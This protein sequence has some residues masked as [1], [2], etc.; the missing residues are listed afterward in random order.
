M[1]YLKLLGMALKMGKNSKEITVNGY[2]FE[3]LFKKFDIGHIDLLKT[4][5]K[6]CECFLNEQVFTNV[7][8][9]K[10]EFET[11]FN[12]LKL[13]DFLKMLKNAGF[14]CIVYRFNPYN[15]TFSNKN[16]CH[17]YGVKKHLK[18]NT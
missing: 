9:V 6:G 11:M 3:S 12:S 2:S 18:I 15:N 17:I 1:I 8:R 5:C 13:D 4:D 7:D 10:I 16:S 14:E